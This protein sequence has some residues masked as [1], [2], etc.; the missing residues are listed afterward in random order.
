M[1]E[2]KIVYEKIEFRGQ[3]GLFVR[4]PSWERLYINTALALVDHLV[5]IT[6]IESEARQAVSLSAKDLPN[7]MEKWMTTICR[8]MTEGRFVPRRIVFE[9]FDGKSIGAVI[10]G[11]AYDPIRHGLIEEISVA[12]DPELAL[13]EGS[14]SDFFVK[15]FFNE[16]QKKAAKLTIQRQAR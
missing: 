9:K 6:R 8:L 15:I 7:L 13:G 5:G 10:H 16:P 4:A 1:P 3:R 14:D 2:P 11:E 12:K